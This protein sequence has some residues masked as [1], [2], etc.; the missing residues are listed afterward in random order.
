MT[1]LLGERGDGTSTSIRGGPQNNFPNGGQP[2]GEI[3][4]PAGDNSQP[5]PGGREMDGNNPAGGG[6][7][8]MAFSGYPDY[9]EATVSFNNLV[10]ENVGFRF[11]GNSTLN[12]T[13]KNGSLKY[14]LNWI[15]MNLKIHLRK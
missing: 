4:N 8:G 5:R 3:L 6:N 1:Q 14:H 9:F 12:Q 10:W 2:P 11:K 13:W 15:L 7:F